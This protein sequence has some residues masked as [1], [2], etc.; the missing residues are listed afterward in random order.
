MEIPAYKK[1]G[2]TIRQRINDGV[3]PLGGQLPTELELVRE[4]NVSR[5]TVSKGLSN[6]IASGL[7]KRIR[8]KG[9]FVCSQ[10]FDLLEKQLRTPV[11][12]CIFPGAI[13]EQSFSN[14]S[15]L[16]GICAELRSSNYQTG[17][18]FCTTDDEIAAELGK[19]GTDDCA[20][21]ILWP[22]TAPQVLNAVLHLQQSGFP[23][24]L[25]DSSVPDY[26]GEFIE[27]DNFA[28]SDLAIDYLRNHGHRRLAYLTLRPERTSLAERLAGVFSSA[29]RCNVTLRPEHLGFVDLEQGRPAERIPEAGQTQIRSFLERLAAT[30]TA[31]RPTALYTSNDLIAIEVIKIA[32]VLKLRIPDELSLISFD[33]I[34]S[35][36]WLSVPLTTM[37]H[38][39][40]R[41]GRL[42]AQLIVDRCERNSVPPRSL[43]VRH[44]YSVKPKLVERCTVAFQKEISNVP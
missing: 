41:I 31:E 23:L 11:I 22:T 32:A 6:L 18:V 30:P 12:K 36:K 10:K 43:T 38:D 14:N 9:S 13:Y 7:V 26:F 2:N 25:L 3:Y 28:G 27:T 20:G 34:D 21:Y 1:L 19:I 15:L 35:A 16:Q 39:F 33:N 17:I 5:M 44:C 37:E 42:A 29:N 24:I 8:G 40:D 4:F